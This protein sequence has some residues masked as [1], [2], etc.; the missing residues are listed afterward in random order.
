MKHT[1]TKTLARPHQYLDGWLAYRRITGIS[2]VATTWRK[3]RR[4]ILVRAGTT[5]R[6]V[7]LGSLAVSEGD[8]ELYSE[9]WGSCA[10]SRKAEGDYCR[11]F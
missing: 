6:T 8:D 11:L 1:V 10:G 9:S 5:G 7:R 4:G 3:E 2:P